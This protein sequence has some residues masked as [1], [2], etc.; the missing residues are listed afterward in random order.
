MLWVLAH[1]VVVVALAPP[2]LAVLRPLSSGFGL[3][4]LALSLFVRR[5]NFF[6]VLQ[7]F[8]GLQLLLVFGILASSLL[9]YF[10]IYVVIWVLKLN[11]A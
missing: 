1:G 11:C 8:F 4:A 10:A 5:F 7:L 2:V 6:F 9:L 3:L